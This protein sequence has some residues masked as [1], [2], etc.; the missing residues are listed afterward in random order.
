[1]LSITLEALSKSYGATPVVR[2]VSLRIEPGELFFLLGGSGCGK[3]TILRMIAGF[4]E[5]TAGR[6][7]FDGMDVT[8]LPAEK[9][10]CGMVF[11]SYA[12]WPHMTVE[13]NVAF[14]LEVAKVDKI[15]I[16]RRVAQALAL[17]RM[18]QYAARKPHELS[19][20]QQQRVALARAVAFGPRVLLLD[21]P[22][23]NLDAKLRTEMRTEIV[24]VCKES[25][26]TAIYVTHDQEEA[27]SMADRMAVMHEGRLEQV[28][29]PRDL[30]TKPQTRFIASF[31]GET[32]LATA[33]VRGSPASGFIAYTPIGDIR[34]TS[35]ERVGRATVS[36]RPEAIHI[37]ETV[38]PPGMHEL[39]KGKLLRSTNLGASARHTFCCGGEE[40]TVT[41]LNPRW[42]L[43]PGDVVTLAVDPRN[44]ALMY[45]E[46]SLASSTPVEDH[47]PFAHVAAPEPAR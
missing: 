22:L 21:E 29:T 6:I 20:G 17:V 5:P 44:V 2:D 45:G 39:S 46:Q 12:L 30:Y 42:D 41:E 43:K 38:P 26:M 4:I 10:R 32:N 8:R 16:A 15:A 23:S 13:Q 36:I 25:Q 35:S 9:R 33:E 34:V 31:L 37:V 47:G 19:G 11:Q 27:L 14:G 18:E 3:T 7:L 28:G 1:M 40:I 24:R